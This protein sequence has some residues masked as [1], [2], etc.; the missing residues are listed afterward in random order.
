VAGNG[1]ELREVLTNLIFNAVDAM[2]KG[3]NI[4]LR[5]RCDGNQVVL[6]VSDTGKGMTEEVRQRCFEPFFTTKGA[7]GT[8]LGLSM[9]H[10]IL[11]RHQA[12]IEIKSEVDKGSTFI[13]R[14]RSQSAQPQS[15]SPAQPANT[16]Q[17]LHVLVVDDE[18]MVRNVVGEYL[19]IDGH[20]VQTAD[21]GRDGLEKF[22]KD[23]FDLVLVDR[24]MPDMNGD[25]VASAI[26][27]TNPS[28][29]VVMLTGFGSMMEASGERP[30]SV[31]LVVG[32][33]VTICDLRAAVTKAL[34]VH[35]A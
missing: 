4:S 16:L 20:V 34:A 9:V 18:A 23:Q 1:A 29:P 13:I 2:P 3:G 17:N 7:H 31:D 21:G 14:F 11:Q 28:M 5:T 19:K 26:K 24:A 12:T 6:E 8:G 27:S 35:A 32:K 22:H 33:P 30:P 25:Q 15:A 10:G